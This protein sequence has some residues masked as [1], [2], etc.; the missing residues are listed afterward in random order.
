MSVRTGPARRFQRAALA[1]LLLLCACSAGLAVA[2]APAGAA[3][4]VTGSGSSYVALAMDDWVRSSQVRGIRVTY[5]GNLGSPGGVD[6][7]SSRQVDFA[8]T[9]AEVRSL[10]NGDPDLPR[11]YQYV[12]DVA[13]AVSIMYNVRDAAGNKINW[14]HLSQ[15][16]VSKIFTGAISRWSHPEISADNRGVRLPDQPIKVVYRTGRS[17]TTAL[18]YDFVREAARDVYEPWRERHRL[19]DRRIVEL[20]ERGPSGSFAPNIVGMTTSDAMAA[21]V[22][23]RNGEWSIGY[24][25]FGYAIKH[26]APAA[27]IRNGAGKWVQPYA[28]N[29]AEALKDAD[30]RADLSQE[31][32][33]V[34]TSRRAKAYPISAYSYM[35]VQCHAGRGRDTCRGPYSDGGKADTLAKFMRFVACDGQVKMARIGYSPLPP[36]LSQEMVNSIA[37]MTGRTAEQL[38]RGNCANPTFSG[39]LGEGAKAPDDPFDRLNGGNGPG[40]NG[41]SGGPSAGAGATA[42]AGAGAGGPGTTGPG[43]GTG[44]SRGARPVGFNGPASPGL[45]ALPVLVLLL[46]L[47]VPPAVIAAVRRRG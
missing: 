36:N 10:M 31:L 13:G 7:Y 18:F 6:Q 11:G 38:S 45:G 24:D 1:A 33:G 37:R 8:G 46:T 15:R 39:G 20:P 32:S 44:Q 3:T 30:L 47:A 26:N 40:G 35:M 22:A 42:G 9:E 27:Y 5:N 23:S 41:P 16:T 14:L 4:L 19:P 12:P 28:E 29:I 25:E 34:Y 17:G 2:A 21:Y 43:T